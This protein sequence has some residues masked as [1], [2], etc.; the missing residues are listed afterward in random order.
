LKAGPRDG[1]TQARDATATEKGGMNEDRETVRV[2]IPAAGPAEETEIEVFTAPSDMLIANVIYTPA[3]DIRGDWDRPRYMQLRVGR[4]SEPG[5]RYVADASAQTSAFYLP[6]GVPQNA[7]LVW[8]NRLRIREGETLYWSSH[9][10]RSRF[11]DG[12]PDPGGTVEILLEPAKTEESSPAGLVPEHWRGKTLAIEHRID[13][14]PPGGGTAYVSNDIGRFVGATDGGIAV[15]VETPQTLGIDR[16]TYE[17][18]Y[19]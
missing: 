12:I 19:D 10:V 7:E 6:A 3:D 14:V 8:T 11:A 2:Q 17:I 16:E 5:S 4:F 15:E 1:P 18:P 13:K 9:I